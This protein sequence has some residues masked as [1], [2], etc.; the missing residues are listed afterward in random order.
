MHLEGIQAKPNM[1]KAHRMLHRASNAPV[2]HM[3]PC[4]SQKCVLSLFSPAR[5]TGRKKKNT[6]AS[7]ATPASITSITSIICKQALKKPTKIKRLEMRRS[8]RHSTTIPKAEKKKQ[9][10]KK[11]GHTRVSSF[12][13]QAAR[14][15]LSNVL[16]RTESGSLEEKGRHP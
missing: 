11:H 4:R 2:P 5:D 12:Y 9:P 10:S 1:Q 6:P 3:Q 7:P 14:C 13:S 16:I 15:R 8:A